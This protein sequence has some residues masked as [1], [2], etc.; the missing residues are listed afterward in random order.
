MAKDELEI[1]KLKAEIL[2]LGRSAWTRPATWINLFGAIAVVIAGGYGWIRKGIELDRKDLELR[3]AEIARRKA[4]VGLDRSRAQTAQEVRRAEAEA[5]RQRELV[6]DANAEYNDMLYGLGVLIDEI[7][8]D[9]LTKLANTL[10]DYEPDGRAS[11]L[12]KER[13]SATRTRLAELALGSGLRMVPGD[14]GDAKFGEWLDE[15]DEYSVQ[16]LD[17][18]SCEKLGEYSMFRIGRMH[19]LRSLYL[20]RSS[21]L[22]DSW[23]GHFDGLSKLSF[24]DL[25]GCEGLTDSCVPYITALSSLDRLN[26]KGCTGLSNAAIETLRRS[27]RSVNWE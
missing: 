12:F 16:Y 3:E 8:K 4:E 13:L 7:Y 18:S 19:Q 20:S 5:E 14:L 1:E 27:V 23:L 21:K 15:I 11:T 17:A 26:L 2:D 6:I 10:K 25:K 9:D 22:R 24:L